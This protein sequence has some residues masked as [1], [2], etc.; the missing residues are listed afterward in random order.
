M[1]IR[2]FQQVWFVFLDGH[3]PLVL[4]SLDLLEG[5]FFYENGSNPINALWLEYW[6]RLSLWKYYGLSQ[7][8]QSLDCFTLGQNLKDN[9]ACKHQKVL[10]LE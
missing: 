4:I 5:R 8:P 3:Q 10:H 6:T 7:S 2:M 1:G 9:V